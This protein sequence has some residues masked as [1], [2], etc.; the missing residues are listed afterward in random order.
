MTHLEHLISQSGLKKKH[1]ARCIDKTPRTLTEYCKR[2]HN[3]PLFTAFRLSQVLKVN[4][5]DL[6]EPTEFSKQMNI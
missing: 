3:I 2:P 6:F 1:I 5:D 4:V